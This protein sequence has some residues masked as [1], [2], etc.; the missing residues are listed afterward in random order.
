MMK[1]IKNIHNHSIHNAIYRSRNGII[2]GICQGIS[3]H[4][5]FSVFWIRAILVI[6]LLVSGVFP[7]VFLY[8]LAS[9][10]IKPEPVKPLY[11]KNEYE[12]YDSYLH[13]RKMALHRLN[14]TFKSLNHRIQRLEDSVTSRE[15]DWET[16]FRK[17]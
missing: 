12:F 1:N 7:I 8:I 5:D 16:R 9:L 3:E 6:F 15:F 4:F 14:N 11:T 17:E 10:I 2:F 13:S